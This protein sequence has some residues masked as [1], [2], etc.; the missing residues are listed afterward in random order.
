[1]SRIKV[2]SAGPWF[3]KEER[4]AITRAFEVMSADED[5]DVYSPLHSHPLNVKAYAS[6]PIDAP[7]AMYFA[8]N[9]ERAPQERREVFLEDVKQVYLADAMT[10]MIEGW[11]P[12]TI[13]EFGMGYMRRFLNGDVEH[14]ISFPIFIAWSFNPAR[15]VNLMIQ[16]AA[17]AFTTNVELLPR[18]IKERIHAARATE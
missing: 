11:D 13:F 7:R 4:E 10:I 8:R 14:P 16:Q 9:A 15:Q 18:L 5:F 3:C 2:Y 12:G 6:L 17:D 1:M